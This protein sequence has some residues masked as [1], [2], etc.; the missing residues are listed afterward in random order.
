MRFAPTFIKFPSVAFKAVPMVVILN[1][2]LSRH[3][4][5]GLSS[6][7]GA[8]ENPYALRPDFHKVSKCCL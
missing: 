1:M 4:N 8:R 3:F 2:A 7:S 6:P 5:G